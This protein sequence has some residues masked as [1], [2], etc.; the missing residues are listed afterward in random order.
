MGA[1]LNMTAPIGQYDAT[2]LLNIGTHRW[3]F[4]PQIGL[5]QA[6]GR[7]TLE[8]LGAVTFYTA[9]GD[10]FNGHVRQQAPLYSGQ[11][12]R[13]LHLSVGHLGR[14]GRDAV[15]RREDHHRR[16]EGP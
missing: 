1:S 3:S 12:E 14:G 10:F 2:K 15:R 7:L 5:S 13:H 8:F 16:R 11:F 9:N 6:L 4:R